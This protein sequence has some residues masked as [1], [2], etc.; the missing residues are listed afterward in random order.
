MIADR[1]TLL[2]R[3]EDANL[4]TRVLEI[5]QRVIAEELDEVDIAVDDIDGV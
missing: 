5:D 2:R 4:D 3:Q 1:G